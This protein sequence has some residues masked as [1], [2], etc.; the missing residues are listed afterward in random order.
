MVVS[1]TNPSSGRNATEEDIEKIAHL[2]SSYN[3]YNHVANP[4]LVAK[5][6]SRFLITNVEVSTYSFEYVCVTHIVEKYF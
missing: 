5:F 3:L 2:S 6:K 1:T 4:L